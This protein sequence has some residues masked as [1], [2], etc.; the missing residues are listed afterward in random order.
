MHIEH[1]PIDGLMILI[2]SV[3][4]DDRG[5]FLETYQQTKFSDAGISDVFV[6][7]NEA[8]SATGVLRGL[9]YQTG[10]FAQSKLVR[11]IRG[12]VYDVAVDLRPGS[13]TYGHWYGLILSGENKRQLYIPRGFAHGYLALEDDTVFAYK[14]D[15]VYAREYEGGIRY[16]DPG[17][18]ITWPQIGLPYQVSE[19]DLSLPPFG[20]HLP[21]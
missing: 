19:K 17:L 21:I 15:N 12:S 1:T 16:D 6:Q 2:P 9:H 18:N 3:Y 5:Y 4:H 7:D 20:A 13:A 11:V 10:T 8:T 14:C